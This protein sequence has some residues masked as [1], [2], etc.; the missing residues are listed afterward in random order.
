MAFTK[1]ILSSIAIAI[2]ALTPPSIAQ[3]GNS[4][5]SIR[6]T[7]RANR[8]PPESDSGPG[9]RG[10]CV[11]TDIPPIAVVG[12][13]N[14]LD[15]TLGERPTFWIYIPYQKSDINWAVFVLQDETGEVELVRT[16]LQLPDTPGIVAV[17]LPETAPPLEVGQTYRWYLE[18]DCVGEENTGGNLDAAAV[19]QGLV[20]RI[21]SPE[22]ETALRSA[23]TPS[24]RVR[25]YAENGLWYDAITELGNLRLEDPTNSQLREIWT[26]LLSD[27]TVGL[28]EISREPIA[29]LA[30]PQP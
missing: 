15:L 24:D 7:P 13:R 10:T 19:V 21:S 16:N 1:S 14:L 5:E 28:E 2:L 12:R 23:Q 26:Q 8:E 17:P 27:E 22:V 3:S 11:K 29:G 4:E 18:M 25:I 30:V 20:T 9:T 6:F